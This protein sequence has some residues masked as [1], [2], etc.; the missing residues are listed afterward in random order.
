MT[1]ET[2]NIFSRYAIS[3]TCP[4]SVETNTATRLSTFFITRINYGKKLSS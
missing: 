1:V 4:N 2:L 3:D